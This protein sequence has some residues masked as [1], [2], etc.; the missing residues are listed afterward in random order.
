MIALIFTTFATLSLL[1]VFEEEGLFTLARSP[2]L[3]RFPKCRLA[4]LFFVQ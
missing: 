3:A 4:A 1:E 2:E